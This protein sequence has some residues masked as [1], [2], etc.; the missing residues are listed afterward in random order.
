M[1]EETGKMRFGL[2][3]G[4]IMNTCKTGADSTVCF[5]HKCDSYQECYK[6]LNPDEEGYIHFKIKTHLI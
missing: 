6:D 3:E 2:L 4:E 1:I 5:G